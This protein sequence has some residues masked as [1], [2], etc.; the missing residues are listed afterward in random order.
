MGLWKM[1]LWKRRAMASCSDPR[2]CVTL[3]V[4]FIS[5]VLCQCLQNE[6]LGADDNPLLILY[7]LHDPEILEK[8][9]EE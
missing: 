8:A 5:A 4:S 3:D 9:R 6:R 7:T 1:G 2:S